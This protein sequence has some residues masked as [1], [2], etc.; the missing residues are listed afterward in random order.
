M[1]TKSNRNHFIDLLKGICIVFVIV[2]HF[3]WT[4]DEKLAYFFPYWLNMAVPLFM[5]ISGYVYAFSYRKNKI[6]C[7]SEA[8]LPKNVIPKLIRYTIPYMVAFVIEISYMISKQ[9]LAV[10]GELP[11]TLV[12]SFI[13]GGFGPG[14]YYYPMMIQFV[15][16]YPVVYFIV[17]RYELKGVL[18]VGLLNA[19]YELIQCAYNMN[20]GCYR[21]LIF[22]YLLLIA[23]GCY[24]SYEKIKW[25]I[26]LMIASFVIGVLFILNYSYREYEPR[27]VT[28]WTKTSFVACLYVIPI[29]IIMIRK[30]SK[31][32]FIPLEFMG[33]ASYNIFLTQMVWYKFGFKIM[34]AQ[35]TDRLTLLIA[36]IAICVIV[37]IVFY[38]LENPV[39][40]FINRKALR[41][42]N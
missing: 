36:D 15:F 32:R 14:T 24:I 7:F 28:H 37:G 31:V 33:K 40:C 11:L 22:R 35:V 3:S 6:E 4:E 41:Y 42:I 16:V 12:K 1:S 39:T 27:V 20:Y 34:K 9:K 19:L 38:Y 2:T 8:Y 25:N 29:A 17:K 18:A 30:F 21:L 10:D 13:V 5:I 23:V 26:P